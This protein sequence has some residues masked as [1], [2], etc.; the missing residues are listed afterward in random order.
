M[1]YEVITIEQRIVGEGFHRFALHEQ[2]FRADSE[3]PEKL[4]RGFRERLGFLS[5]E[6][7]GA[8]EFPLPAQRKYGQ[9]AVITSYSI[10]YTKLYD[11][12]PLADRH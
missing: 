2:G 5:A 12:R 7:E 6:D 9:R 10:H 3:N 8:D 11:R 1:L 4:Y